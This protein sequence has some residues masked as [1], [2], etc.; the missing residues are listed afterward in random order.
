MANGGGPEC[1]SLLPLDFA[2]LAALLS[3]PRSAARCAEI[4]HRSELPKSTGKSEGGGYAGGGARSEL[5]EFE[6]QQAA[7]VRER[8]AE[9]RSQR[10]ELNS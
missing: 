10:S 3:F 7:A 4:E 1:G 9:V 8:V 2:Q 6:R 5:R